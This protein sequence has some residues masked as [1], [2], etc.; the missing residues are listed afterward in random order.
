MTQLKKSASEMVAE[1]KG[2]IE[3]LSPAEVAKEV[4]AGALL[5]DIREPGE[6]AEKGV[7]RGAL[8][9]VRGMLEFYADPGVPYHKPEFVPGRRIIL[10]CAAGGRSALAA[11]ALIDMG[12]DAAH[13]E[14]GFGA[15]SE[16]GFPT[17][18]A[19][20]AR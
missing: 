14:G 3:N 11:A 13:L 15:W 12:H 20:E 17:E 18:A 4:E 5:V 1:A 2:R 8:P 19:P 6:R 10:H 7:I 9:A 16:G